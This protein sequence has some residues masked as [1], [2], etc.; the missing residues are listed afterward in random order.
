ML[1][2][3]IKITTPNVEFLP[4]KT[5]G[6]FAE[7]N[8]D[9]LIVLNNQYDISY[10]RKYWTKI[11]NKIDITVGDVEYYCNID[12]IWMYE[13]TSY[14]V[15][16]KLNII[17]RENKISHAHS[18]SMAIE[19]MRNLEIKRKKENNIDK[20][21]KS[22][23]DH[24]INTPQTPKKKSLLLKEWERW[25]GIEYK[26]ETFIPDNEVLQFERIIEKKRRKHKKLKE[27]QLVGLRRFL[28]D[29][30]DQLDEWEIKKRRK[31]AA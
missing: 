29:Y 18:L 9:L 30:Y 2:T 7:M 24:T 31:K 1:Q 26:I 23:K 22:N 19:Y 16:L 11:N 20:D 25:I 28:S 12:E 13:N 17:A 5:N 6:S 4:I 8:D 10:L 14:M 27:S 15:G 21:E 3:S